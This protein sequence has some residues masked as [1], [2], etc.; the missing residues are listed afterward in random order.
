[1][2]EMC[3]PRFFGPYIKLKPAEKGQKRGYNSG[4]YLHGKFNTDHYKD[5]MRIYQNCVVHC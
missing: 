1:M 4:V 3:V 5:Q 2:V